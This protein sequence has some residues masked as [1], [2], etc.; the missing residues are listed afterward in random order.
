VR[1][2]LYVILNRLKARSPAALARITI[3]GSG[4]SGAPPQDTPGTI[5]TGAH[6]NDMILPGQTHR[7]TPDRFITGKC[8][9]HCLK[10]E[11]TK[12][13]EGTITGSAGH[14]SQPPVAVHPGHHHKAHR[15]RSPPGR[16]VTT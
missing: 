16:M 2:I 3:T 11:T 10:D 6:G 4:S 15:E 14:G 8:E 1:K 7:P 13:T 5:T 12:Q 9:G